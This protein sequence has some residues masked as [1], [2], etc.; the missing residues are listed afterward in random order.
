MAK[1]RHRAQSGAMHRVVRDVRIRED[2]AATIRTVDPRDDIPAGHRYH[3]DAVPL[4]GLAGHVDQI[5]AGRVL[6]VRPAGVGRVIRRPVVSWAGWCDEHKRRDH[7]NE[8]PHRLNGSGGDLAKRPS[9]RS[10]YELLITI[11]LRG[12]GLRR[13]LLERA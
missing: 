10:T 8:A 2:P 5:G 13:D 12:F 3:V 11:P 1:D 7:R 9:Y 6:P 4:G